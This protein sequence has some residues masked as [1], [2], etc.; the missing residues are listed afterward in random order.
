MTMMM[1]IYAAYIVKMIYKKTLCHLI[2]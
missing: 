2:N 1:Q